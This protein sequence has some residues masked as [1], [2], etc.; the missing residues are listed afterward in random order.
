MR[1]PP[2]H[3]SVRSLAIDFANSVACPACGAGDGL[4]TTREA[5][6]WVR[7]KTTGMAFRI[8]LPDLRE[9]RR[10]RARLRE[11]LDSGVR[12]AGPPTAALTEINRVLA[13]SPSRLQ[14]RWTREGWQRAEDREAVS[15]PRAFE[16]LVSRSAVALLADPS[17]PPVRRCE[18]PECVH[19]LI[20]RTSQQ[21]W[22]SPTG[23]GN[24]ARVQ[25]HYRKMRPRRPRTPSRR[26]SVRRSGRPAAGPTHRG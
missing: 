4:A 12:H 20:A 2:V 17:S 23:C 25:R 26:A 15:G 13:R 5:E 11:L 14:L 9:L 1:S 10:L 24:R 18:G 21:R 22:C 8:S 7:R 3:E 19:F 6:R 16:A